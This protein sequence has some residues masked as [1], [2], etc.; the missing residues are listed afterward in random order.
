M[1][2]RTA[3]QTQTQP[4]LAFHGPH[5]LWATPRHSFFS[6]AEARKSE[7]RNPPGLFCGRRERRRLR[8]ARA[9]PPV[10]N[11]SQPSGDWQ[12][13]VARARQSDE[14]WG[15]GS[16]LAS[17][18]FVW[19]AIRQYFPQEFADRHLR[20]W[21]SKLTGYFSPYV[22]IS[23][24][25]HVGERLQRSEAFAA[26]ESFLG[27][28]CGGGARRLRAELGKES[29]KLVLSMDEHEEVTDN[30]EGASFWWEC[31]TTSTAAPRFSFYPAP[32]E[33][34]FYRLTFHRRHRKLATDSY[35]PHVLEKG[36]DASVQ[37]RQRKLYTNS[38]NR[39]AEYRRLLWSHVPFEHPASFDTLAMDPE[40]KRDIIQDLLTFR[41]SKEY[42]A[43]IG[44]PWKRG[45]L[46]YGPPGTGK[47][48]MVAAMANFLEYDVYDLELTAV[49]DNSALRRLLIETTS[50]SIIVIED[51]D[52]SLDLTGKRK[53]EGEK[54]GGEEEDEKKKMEAAATG[55]GD[56][57]DSKV[58]LSGLLNFIDGL[59]SAC[60]GE[61]L[62]VFTTN[63]I[64]KL[65]P[66]LI[67]RGRMDKHIELSYCR[68]EAFKVLARNYLGV[69]SHS[70]FDAIRQLMEEA[71]ITPADVAELLIPR[72]RRG[73]DEEVDACLDGVVAALQEAKAKKEEAV[74]AAEETA[75]EVSKDENRSQAQGIETEA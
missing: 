26:I 35:L 14:R 39:D 7:R 38:P 67:R 16:T 9:K 27:S 45:Y 71:D 20:R 69:D 64:E 55:R 17:I 56:K 19:M 43:R 25:E 37:R 65:D 11:P 40:Q 29:T 59:W 13:E 6:F 53:R 15:M 23:F 8:R 4:R 74:T 34:R 72:T 48:T 18:M 41:E 30:F 51:I 1:T 73:G 5:K 52:C 36:R 3:P 33:K 32:E 61:R 2:R 47:S 62:I 10:I 24:P 22:Q 63:H 68:F 58:T 31:K 70:R 46:L 28:T 60:G 21:A 57:D 49:K 66:A 12:Q 54:S 75:A 42:Y 50:K 44:K